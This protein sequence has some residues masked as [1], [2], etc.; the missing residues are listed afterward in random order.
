MSSEAAL[1]ITPTARREETCLHPVDQ[2]PWGSVPKP[3]E[4]DPPP[5]EDD[6]A[7]RPEAD[8][9]KFLAAVLGI[10]AHA[11]VLRNVLEEQRDRLD[12]ASI[13]EPAYADEHDED[14]A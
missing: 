13:A 3:S 1:A 9:I 6:A 10:E 2:S 12:A 11:D 8:R 14:Q 4:S 7:R 5:E